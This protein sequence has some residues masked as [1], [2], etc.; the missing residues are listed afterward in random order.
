M[1][2]LQCRH[3]VRG[4]YRFGQE[5]CLNPAVYASLT[6][7]RCSHRNSLKDK[8]TVAFLDRS[9]KLRCSECLMVEIKRSYS[10]SEDE[11]ELML[12]KI[13]GKEMFSFPRPEQCY[14]CLGFCSQ[15]LFLV[16][17]GSEPIGSDPSDKALL[18]T[19]RNSVL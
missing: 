16:M 7:C 15:T 2:H 18:Y 6:V 8:N 14:K 19:N 1:S 11:V 12:Q 17:E 9:V 10:F 13:R 4:K 3:T 5:Q